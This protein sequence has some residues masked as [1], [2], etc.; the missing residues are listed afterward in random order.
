M[1]KHL[2]NREFWESAEKNADN[3]IYYYR[4]LV[5]LSVSMFE[6]QNLPETVDERFLELALFGTGMA[7]FFK[8]EEIG[9]LALRCMINGPLNVY[10][11][12]TGRRAYASNGYNMQ[13]DENNS[14]I[15]WNNMIHTP[16]V[17]EITNFSQRL[18][19]L[20]RSIDVNAKA[21]KTPLLIKCEE[22]QRLTLKNLYQK[23][24]GNQPVIFGDKNLNTQETMQVLNTNA[25]Y[26]ADRLY[27]LKTQYW[28]EALTYLG[29]SNLNVQKKERLITDEVMRNMGGTIASRYSRLNARQQAC[30]QINNM[31][32]LDIWCVYREDFREAD[33]ETMFDSATGSELMQDMVLD[34]RTQGSTVRHQ[35]RALEKALNQARQGKGDSE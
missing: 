20:D 15:I 4:R 33:D 22:S 11:I 6:W 1:P 31:F 3:Y 26:V 18:W 17:S 32:D 16:C 5:E 23:Y 21:Q 14:V 24:D 19:D 9:Y 35:N 12:P 10:N 2:H 34:L 27:T 13:L 8:D 25:P 7:V 30:E 29:I 28:N